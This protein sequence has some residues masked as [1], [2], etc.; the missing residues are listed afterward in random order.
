[1]RTAQ[2]FDQLLALGTLLFLIVGSYLVLQPFVTALLWAVLLAYAT[3]PAFAWLNRRWKE[4][5]SLAA[6]TLC[7]LIATLFVGPFVLVGLSLADN[8]D[9]VSAMLQRLMEQGV[10]PPPT[11]VAG[12]PLVGEKLYALWLSAATDIR[13][14]LEPLRDYLPQASK[15]L[16]AHGAPLLNGVLQLTLSVFILFFFYRDGDALT[17][18]LDAAMDRIGGSRAR[19]LLQLAGSTVKGVVYG[20]LGTAVAQGILAGIGFLIA[21]VPGALLLG[22]ATFFLSVVPMGPP[23]IWIPAAA[24]LYYT[25]ETG[26]AIFI[27]IWGVA[28]VS[29]I[30]N[31]LKPY[32]ISQG[33]AMPFLLVLLGVLGGLA[34]FGFVGVF[35]GPTILAVAYS[36]AREWTLNPA[37]Q[38]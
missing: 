6:L 25:G 37:T 30:D 8:V 33:A 22:F 1:M 19:E 14:T 17:L 29:S 11:W 21:G 27:V 34:A 12:V 24:W 32:L 38:Q 4:R 23:L 36:L 26:W 18:R 16:L 31:F 28:V 5:R 35:L 13:G 10:S 2:A 7:L 9:R 3:W 20:I 15:W